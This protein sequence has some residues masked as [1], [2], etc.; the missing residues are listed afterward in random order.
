[1]VG[2]NARLELIAR[3]AVE[4]GLTTVVPPLPDGGEP[5]PDGGTVTPE[6]I[7]LD[8]LGEQML[9]VYGQVTGGC[10]CASGA[11]LFPAALLLLLLRRR[12]RGR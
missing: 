4:L 1:V 9:P 6:P 5:D 12:Q 3:A 11:G 8:S 10:G 2:K 7:V